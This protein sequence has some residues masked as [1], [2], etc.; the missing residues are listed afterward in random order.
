MLLIMYWGI[1][2]K[3]GNPYMVGVIW[4]RGQGQYP[5]DTTRYNKVF[6]NLNT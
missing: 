5:S 1:H 6:F 2:V 4:G 3:E